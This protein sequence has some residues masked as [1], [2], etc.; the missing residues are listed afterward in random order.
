MAYAIHPPLIEPRRRR[1]SM[2][3]ISSPTNG[4]D[5]RGQPWGHDAHMDET[6]LWS[7]TP[8]RVSSL[9]QHRRRVQPYLAGRAR[10]L[11]RRHHRNGATWLNAFIPQQTLYAGRYQPRGLL[12]ARATRPTSRGRSGGARSPPDGRAWTTASLRRP[13]RQQPHR[14]LPVF[15]VQ[16]SARVAQRRPLM[17]SCPT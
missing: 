9:H 1:L 11:R 3:V 6:A 10:A 8:R 4:H 2:P 12:G 14:T 13:S 17:A 16:E 5:R 15:S 7:A